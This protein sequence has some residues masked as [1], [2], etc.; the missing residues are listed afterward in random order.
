MRN[1]S[2]KQIDKMINNGW[3]FVS[4]GP[5]KNLYN[6]IEKYNAENYKINVGWCGT[7]IRGIHSYFLL[8]KS[9]KQELSKDIIYKEETKVEDNM[10]LTKNKEDKL[11]DILYSFRSEKE[12]LS[13]IKNN[14][15]IITE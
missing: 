12:K 4:I 13:Y 14:K 3:Y 6:E 5:E 10:L 8:I 2:D 9:I 15:N 11:W 7:R 1:Y